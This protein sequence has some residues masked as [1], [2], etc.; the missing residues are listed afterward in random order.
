MENNMIKRHVRWRVSDLLKEKNM[1][2]AEL[3]KRAGLTEMTVSYIVRDAYERA[4][5]ETIGKLCKALNCKPSD[6]FILEGEG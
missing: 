1:T 4:G 2:G 5:L 3:A 6:L